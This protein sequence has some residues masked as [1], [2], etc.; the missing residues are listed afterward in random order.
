MREVITQVLLEFR[1]QLLC[2]LGGVMPLEQ[3]LD[4]LAL[5]QHMPLGLA[6][7]PLHHFQLS[8]AD[9][10]TASYRFP[11]PPDSRLLRSMR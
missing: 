8:F 3:V 1:Q 6:D 11:M 2:K 9:S 4:D 7:V 5:A 10:H